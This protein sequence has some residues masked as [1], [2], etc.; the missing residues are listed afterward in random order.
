MYVFLRQ[1]ANSLKPKYFFRSFCGQN[2]CFDKI[3][4][5]MKGTWVLES[6]RFQ[7]SKTIR[8][9]FFT[10]RNLKFRL[11]TRKPT[12]LKYS[13]HGTPCPVKMPWSSKT[14]GYILQPQR[15]YYFHSEL[16]DYVCFRNTE[17]RY[18]AV[19]ASLTRTKPRY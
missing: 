2:I 7:I 1:I 8:L 19:N 5:S 17:I 10:T 14:T 4:L 11:N 18:A 9:H 12:V 13:I 16:H 6:I 3:P 15:C